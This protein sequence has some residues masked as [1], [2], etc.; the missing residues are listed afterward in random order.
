MTWFPLIPLLFALKNIKSHN[1]ISKIMIGFLLYDFVNELSSNIAFTLKYSNYIFHNTYNLIEF[2][3]FAAISYLLNH[4]KIQRKAILVMC[5]ICLG[6]FIYEFSLTEYG[7]ILG[8]VEKAFLIILVFFYFNT[9]LSKLDVENIYHHPPF[10][11]HSGLMVYASLSILNE[12]ATS[13]LIDAKGSVYNFFWK[14]MQ[15]A[16]ILFH[17][18]LAYSFWISGKETKAAI[19]HE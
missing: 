16:T 11:I 7:S 17:L 14:T 15:I 5:L 6:L 12:L 10:W 19:N 8:T 4:S 13:S 2:L 9:L 3:F 1:F 18:I